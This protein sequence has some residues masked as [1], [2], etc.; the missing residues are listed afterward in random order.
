MGFAI[1]TQNMSATEGATFD[2]SSYCTGGDT[3]QQLVWGISQFSLQEYPTYFINGVDIETGNNIKEMTV[4]LTQTGGGVGSTFVSLQASVSLEP[5]PPSPGG[6]NCSSLIVTALAYI[7]NTSDVLFNIQTGITGVSESPL[8]LSGVPNVCAG[9]LSGFS[10]TSS[11]ASVPLGFGVSAGAVL[12]PGKSPTNPSA[13]PVGSGI[14]LVTN[15]K[16]MDTTVDVGSIIITGEQP[17]IVVG[18]I[19]DCLSFNSTASSKT[20]AS[21]VS[22]SVTSPTLPPLSWV[23]IFLQSFALQF[24]I[25]NS[26]EPTPPFNSA[27]VGASNANPTSTGFT[28]DSAENMY[29]CSLSPADAYQYYYAESYTATYFYVGGVATT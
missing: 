2:F 6:P 14:Y 23:A 17:D 11:D 20:A 7:G 15:N 3:I 8:S 13:L 10:F 24:Q 19:V 16:P 27:V 4:S 21:N 12:A 28:F 22:H 5:A 29:S 18:T 25:S 1:V 9:I 26:V